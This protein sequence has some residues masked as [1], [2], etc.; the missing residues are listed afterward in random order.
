MISTFPL[1]FPS[2]KERNIIHSEIPFLN[3]MDLRQ[4]I[5][6]TLKNPYNKLEIKNCSKILGMEKINLLEEFFSVIN[7]LTI[8]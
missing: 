5:D 2:E 1:R 3:S 8:N 7:L 4:Y 6:G